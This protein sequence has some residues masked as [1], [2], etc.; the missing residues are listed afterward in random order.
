M[1][2]YDQMLTGQCGKNYVWTD[3]A[4]L[5]GLDG[6]LTQTEADSNPQRVES[7]ASELN[8]YTT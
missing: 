7:E 1:V 3:E 2:N 6:V 8:L 4:E 5:L